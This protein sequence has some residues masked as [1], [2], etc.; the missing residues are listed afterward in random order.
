MEE[1]V[2]KEKWYKNKKVLLLVALIVSAVTIIGVTFAAFAFTDIGTNSSL[3]TTGQLKLTLTPGRPGIDL[4]YEIPT[5]DE[6]GVLRDPYTFTI[7][8]TGTMSSYYTIKLV[9]DQEAITENDASSRLMDHSKVKIQFNNETPVL[10]SSLTDSELATGILK[11]EASLTSSIRIWIDWDAGNEVM[12]Q[13]VYLK[14][15][16]EATQGGRTEPLFEP[17]PYE[18][19]YNYSNGVIYSYN[20]DVYGSHYYGLCDGWNAVDTYYTDNYG[21]TQPEEHCMDR[22]PDDYDNCYNAIT[23]YNSCVDKYYQCPSFYI[24]IPE[25]LGGQVV[26]EISDSVFASFNSIGYHTL[27]SITF[28]PTITYIGSYAFN[29]ATLFG[30]VSLPRD[31]TEIGENAFA[32]ANLATIGFNDKLETIGNYAFSYNAIN[33]LYLNEGLTSIGE[34]AF[35]FNQIAELTIP[36]S[37]TTIGSSAFEA[38]QI[39]YLTLNEGLETI[40]DYAFN[41]NAFSSVTIPASVTSVGD[42]AFYNN[43]GLN[44]IIVLGKSDDSEFDYAGAEWN[45]G[46]TVTYQ[47]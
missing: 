2:I 43:N 46:V 12:A 17:D 21:G 14:V 8:N 47:P 27:E 13:E 16:V 25:R 6:D 37:V 15:V 22:F 39:Q 42:G 45:D 5:K 34:Y 18:Y 31:L 32:N 44:E 20:F 9:N 23:E 1:Q 30:G 19:C 36:S 41:N 11:E 24:D 29:G 38:N 35:T 7:K 26:T 10:L 3:I 4:N 28:P 40:G 33:E